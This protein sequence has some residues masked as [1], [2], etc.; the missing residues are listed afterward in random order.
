MAITRAKAKLI[1]IG[2]PTCLARDDKWRR[3]MD[4]CTEL[5]CYHGHANQQ[6]ERDEQLLTEIARTRF[7][8]CLLTPAL[9]E[10]KKDEDEKKQENKKKQTR[11]G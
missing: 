2:N 7:D 1:I 5:A 11:K 9:R 6:I 10:I 8:K 3:Y 4:M